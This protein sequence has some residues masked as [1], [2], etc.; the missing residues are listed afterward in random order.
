MCQ[1]SLLWTALVAVAC[2]LD[3]QPVLP[4]HGD[5]SAAPEEPPTQ[6]GEPGA[7][8]GE[9]TAPPGAT[10]GEPTAPPGSAAGGSTSVVDPGRTDDGDS[11]ESADAAGAGGTS[12]AEAEP[13]AG[14]WSTES[15][16]GAGASDE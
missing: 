14:A 9:P 1:K 5:A 3:P 8:P 4:G 2:G 7:T 6:S 13:N 15:V 12:G 16:G 11:G 10:P